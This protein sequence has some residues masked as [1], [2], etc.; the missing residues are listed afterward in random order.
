MRWLL[1]AVGV[2]VGLV[3]VAV[4][5]LWALG[6]RPDAGKDQVSVEIAR[7]PEVVWAWITEPDKLVQWVA[8]LEA[9]ESDPASPQGVGHREVWVVNDPNMKQQMRIGAVVTQ[10]DAPRACAARV[11]VP[12]MFEGE[13]A[14]TLEDLGGG[15]TRLTQ[16]SAFVYTHPLAALM[17]PLVTPEARK[18]QIS[19]FAR[20]KSK[21]E[22]STP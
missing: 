20:L 7:P 19:D 6:R 8:W 2:L 4:G 3:I 14:Y 10:Q 9:V 13:I 12:K 22:A 11:E 1:I 16:K 21:A 5:V 15:R 17:E 18:K